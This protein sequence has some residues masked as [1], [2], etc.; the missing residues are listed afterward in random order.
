[1]SKTQSTELTGSEK[2]WGSRI[3]PVAQWIDPSKEYQTR[4]GRRVISLHI[5]MYNSCGNEV[6]YPVKGS[7]VV[8]EKPLRLRYSIW[9]LDG[10]ENVVWPSEGD[11]LI[12]VIKEEKMDT[13]DGEQRQSNEK[14]LKARNE[15]MAINECLGDI[16]HG[17]TLLEM[18]ELGSRISKLRG[19]LNS[20]A[21]NLSPAAV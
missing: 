19:R 11:D 17:A 12:P 3:I 21:R 18:K 9:S 7:V 10:R 14:L 20:V 2:G 6:T 16:Q 15:L 5:S 13:T 8:R 4:S 1:M